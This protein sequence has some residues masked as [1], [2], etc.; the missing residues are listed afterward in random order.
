MYRVIED[1]A[2]DI[3]NEHIEWFI[4]LL[5]P[6]LFSYFVHGYKHGKEKKEEL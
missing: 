3:A 4:A 1:E 6:L 2:T 5:R